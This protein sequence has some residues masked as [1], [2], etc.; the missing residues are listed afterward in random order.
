MPDLAA[1]A[2]DQRGRRLE[3]EADQ[4]DDDVGLQSRY[5]VTESAV[6]VFLW[7]V[8]NDLADLLPFR[9]VCI[10]FGGPPDLQ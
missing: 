9:C 2:A 5:P 4:V 8:G 3:R 6:P 10:C 1:E 7:P